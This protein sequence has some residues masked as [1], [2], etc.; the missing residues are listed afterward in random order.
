MSEATQMQQGA[1]IRHTIA[2]MLRV[3][4]NRLTILDPDTNDMTPNPD[5]NSM[6][7]VRCGRGF[8]GLDESP[9]AQTDSVAYISD[10]STT[11]TVTGYET[12]FAFTA[13]LIYSELAVAFIYDIGTR[14]LTGG[15]AETDYVRIE[16]FKG[17]VSPGVYPAR[18]F[19]VAIEL[20][21]ISGGGTEKI[22]MDGNLNNV[23]QYEDGTW[24]MAT[25]DF[26][27]LSASAPEPEP[28][29]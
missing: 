17:T 13:D 4:D 1:A 11:T 19:R 2:D 27:P 21:D 16:I 10:T 24:D 14:Q 7:W 26:T 25:R 20:T 15:E 22:V 9:N 28:E 6:V 18:K 8:T 5:Y 3:R 29:P 23:G 12:Q